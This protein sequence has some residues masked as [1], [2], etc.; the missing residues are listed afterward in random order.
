VNIAITTSPIYSMVN[1]ASANKSM[2]GNPMEMA[3]ASVTITSML[4]QE[5]Y[6]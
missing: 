6:A 5:S 4:W 2:V 3:A 1:V